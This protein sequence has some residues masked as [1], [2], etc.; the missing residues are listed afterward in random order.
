[1]VK[2]ILPFPWCR[3]CK[4]PSRKDQIRARFYNTAHHF[5]SLMVYK[6]QLHDGWTRAR[7][8]ELVFAIAIGFHGIHLM[9]LRIPTEFFNKLLCASCIEDAMTA[10]AVFCRVHIDWWH[11]NWPQFFMTYFQFCVWTS[12]AHIILHGDQ[13]DLISWFWHGLIMSSV[14]YE[15]R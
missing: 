5:V 9:I 10:P 12:L 14:A 7:R 1:M 4:N 15:S 13:P 11:H 6:T 8:G 3:N 2:Y